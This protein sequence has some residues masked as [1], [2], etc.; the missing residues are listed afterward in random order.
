M[1]S[2]AIWI[3]IACG[4]VPLRHRRVALVYLLR[5]IDVRQTI[6]RRI[7]D[8]SDEC[9]DLSGAHQGVVFEAIPILAF[10]I[11]RS[12]DLPF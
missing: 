2:L 4:C 8:E 12:D 6:E 10:V 3:G 9:V 11:V 7:R 5:K 1:E